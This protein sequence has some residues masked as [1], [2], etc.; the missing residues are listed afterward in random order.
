MFAREV[1]ATVYTDYRLSVN[2]LSITYELKSER[3]G[4]KRIPRNTRY[5]FFTKNKERNTFILKFFCSLL[6]DIK[7]IFNVETPFVSVITGKF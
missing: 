3:E 5:K 1:L 2:Y 6:F 7:F 4:E